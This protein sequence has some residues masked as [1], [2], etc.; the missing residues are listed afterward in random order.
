MRSGGNARV[1]LHAAPE[2]L[3]ASALLLCAAPLLGMAAADEA[4]DSEPPVQVPTAEA[5]A[6]AARWEPPEPSP[7][8]F[9]WIRLKSGEWLKGEIERM[10]DE[11]MVFDSDELET[12]ELD[13]DDISA[14]YSPHE[15]SYVFEGR[16]IH[17]GTA[18][19]RDGRVVVSSED[20]VREFERR[21]LVSIVPGDRS[22]LSLWS[23]KLSAGLIA[24]A[25]NT[26][27]TDVTALF[28]I[29]REAPVVRLGLDYNG[30]LSSQSGQ[31]TANNARANYATDVYLS[32]RFFV[33]VPSLSFYRDEFQNIEYQLT[34]GAAI[35]Y[36]LVDNRWIDW[37]VGVG[38]A[39]QYTAF[40]SVANDSRFSQD[41]AAVFSTSLDL[42]ITAD[43]ELD[44]DYR[45]QLG[46]TDPGL[47]TQ[48]LL[49]TLSVDILG[50]LEL[51]VSFSWDRLEQ[52]VPNAD[53]T[54]PKSNDYRLSV[55][56]GIDF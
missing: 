50:P 55:G 5:A 7:T 14:I 39:Y 6:P 30:A 31:R 24:R 44:T 11:K 56:L 21:K 27:S 34:P 9:D 53:G 47:T 25:G 49:S 29:R 54:V 32:R 26:Q 43:I 19:M 16:R 8:E 52:P 3:R 18:T 51:D 37:E 38:A 48:H 22:E 42:D 2:W 13:W 1:V 45:L 15:H 40:I 10:R 4:A 33:T 46:L 17:T 36:D 28:N 41:V 20:G 12:L 23:G 35:G